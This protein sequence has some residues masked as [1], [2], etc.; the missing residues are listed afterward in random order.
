VSVLWVLP[1]VVLALGGVALAAAVAATAKALGE[2]HA[3]LG[4]LDDI[5]RSIVELRELPPHPL[6]AGPRAGSGHRRGWK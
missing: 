6:L 4:R 1:V 2:L 5:R 3:E